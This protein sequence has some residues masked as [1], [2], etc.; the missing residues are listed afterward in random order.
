MKSIIYKI[1]FA[2]RENLANILRSLVSSFGIVFLITFFVIYIS[3]RD[4]VTS[5]VKGSLF[6][7]L[8]S[9]EIKILPAGSSGIEFI[10]R[11][12]VR[13]ISVR[14]AE[15]IRKMKDFSSVQGVMRIGLNLKV[16][17]ELMGKARTMYIP[18]AGIDRSFLKGKAQKWQSFYNTKPVPIIAPKYTIDMFNSYLAQDN[19]PTIP[20]GELVGFPLTLTFATGAKGAT[21][22]K[23]YKYEGVIHGFTDLINFPGLVVP[24]DF[25]REISGLYVKEAKKSSG[26]E[27]IVLFAKVKDTNQLPATVTALKKMGLKVESQKD[28]TE[29]ANK[30]MNIIDGFSVGVIAIFFILTAIS[31]FN[32]YLTIVLIRTQMFSLKRVLGYSKLH[33]LAAFLAEAAFIGAIYGAVGYYAGKFLLEQF[34]TNIAKFIP[35]LSGISVQP[36]GIQVLLMCITISAGISAASAFFP[37]LFASNMNLFK[38]VRR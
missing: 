17:A 2:L 21:D 11:P 25:L 6:D 15:S 13:G 37:A 19:L 5:Y 14:E 1:Y 12:G 3:F 38:A 26:L 20:E 35:A 30:A 10:K 24:S 34:S 8:A 29:K 7:N 31:I 33:I 36:G 27:Y 18:V 28:I 9:D 23:E 32:S 22:R 4:S 16:R